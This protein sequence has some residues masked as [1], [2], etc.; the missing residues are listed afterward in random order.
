MQQPDADW[1]TERTRA[2]GEEHEGDGGRQRKAGPCRE[3]ATIA[4]PHEA[5]GKPDLAAGGAGQELAQPH[6]IGIG[7]FVEPAPA[8][9]E[10]FAE[11]S[12]VSNRPAEAGDAQLEEC[13]QHFERRPDAGVCSHRTVRIWCHH[14]VPLLVRRRQSALRRESKRFVDAG[15][16]AEL[17]PT[18]AMRQAPDWRP[19]SVAIAA[20]QRAF[21]SLGR[22]KTSIAMR[23]NMRRHWSWTRFAE[24]GLRRTGGDGSDRNRKCRPN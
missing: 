13:K 1:T 2:I 16:T 7:L 14:Y 11:I 23:G 6:Q 4:G 12:D 18:D 21:A 9:D 15:S 8:H 5:D 3:T 10:L 24:R 20:A 19:T 22:V 17:S